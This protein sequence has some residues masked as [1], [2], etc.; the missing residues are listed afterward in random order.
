MS[1]D[2]HAGDI[3]CPLNSRGSGGSARGAIL[4][5]LADLLGRTVAAPTQLPAGLLAA[6][7]GAPYFFWLLHKS[8]RKA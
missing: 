4:L 5:V 2:R 6:L 8:R 7:V 1:R 3:E